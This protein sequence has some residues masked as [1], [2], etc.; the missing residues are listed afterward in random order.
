M[1]VFDSTTLLHLL[2]EDARAAHD[3]ETGK[4]LTDATE[5]IRQLAAEI[6]QAGETVLVPTPV[7]SEVLVHAG[8][9]TSDYLD[10]LANTNRFRIAPFGKRAAVE[11][12]TMTRQNLASRKRRSVVSRATRAKLKFDS[13]SVAIARAEGDSTIYSDDRDVARI[14]MDFGLSVIPTSAVEPPAQREM[15]FVATPKGKAE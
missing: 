13:Q 10:I 1:A 7:L 4:P 6:E 12:A 9:A 15:K 3:P 14:G 8:E 2:E 5:R 11:L